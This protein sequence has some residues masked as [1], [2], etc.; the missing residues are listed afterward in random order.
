MSVKSTAAD[1]DVSGAGT[2]GVGGISLRELG[3][4]LCFYG[5][6]IVPGVCDI[7]CMLEMVLC[8]RVPRNLL[9]E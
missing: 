2:E 9:G 4:R 6:T 8:Q 3:R 5:H 1:A 7:L